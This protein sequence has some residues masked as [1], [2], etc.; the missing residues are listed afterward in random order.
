[1]PLTSDPKQ[2]GGSGESYKSGEKEIG[3]FM[4]RNKSL[5]VNQ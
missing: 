3:W 4:T 2:G 5:R 1:M